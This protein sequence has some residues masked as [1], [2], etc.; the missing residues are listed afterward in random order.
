MDKINNTTKTYVSS[1]GL[2]DD[3]NNLLAVGKFNKPFTK[4][5]SME[6]VVNVKFRRM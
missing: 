5:S 1:I 6:Y 3:S 2:Y 4:D